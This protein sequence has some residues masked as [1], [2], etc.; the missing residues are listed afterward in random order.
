MSNNKQKQFR[1]KL[2][3]LSLCVALASAACI[4][5]PAFAQSVS[6]IKTQGDMSVLLQQE[7][8]LNFSAGS[9]NFGQK[10][11]IDEQQRYQTIDGLGYAFTQGSAEEI[12]KLSPSAQD[13]LLNEMFHPT[14][15]RGISAVRISIG[16]SDL[17]TSLYSY[18][19]AASSGENFSPDPNKSYYIDIPAHG[20][21]IGATGSG[22]QPYTGANAPS[23]ADFEWRFVPSGDGHW[24]IDRAS[25]GSLPR[26]RTDDTNMADMDPNTSSGTWEKWALSPGENA[27]T[28]FLSLPLKGFGNHDRLQVDDNAL[29]RMADNDQSAGTWESFSFTEVGATTNFSL[30]GPDMQDLIPLLQKI[31]AINP[32]VKILA[33]PWS[34]PRRMKTNNA[35]V[36]GKLRPASYSEYAQYFVQYIDAMAMNGI[37]I[38]AITPQNEP[39][40]NHNSPSMEMTAQEQFD[41]IDNHLG[42]ALQS[43]NKGNVKIIG[44][45]HNCDNTA[46][47]ITVAQSQFVDGSAF[48]LYAGD[49]SAMTTVKEATGKNVYFT[50]QW[51]QIPEDNTNELFEI[52]FGWHMENVV[53][54]SIRN[55]SKAVFEWNFATSGHTDGGCLACLGAVDIQAGDGVKRNVSY[56]ILS[57][58]GEYL[59]AGATRID[60]GQLS[61]TIHHVAF[62]NP[63]GSQ[64]LL[65]YNDDLIS[66]QGISVDWDGKFLD[67]TIPPNSAVTLHW[68]DVPPTPTPTP[69][70]VPSGKVEAEDFSAMSGVLLEDTTDAGGGQNVGWIDTG[71]WMRYDLILDAAGS[72]DL[73]LRVAS[74]LS[75]GAFDVALNGVLVAQVTVPNTNGWQQWQ[76]LTR[77]I[78]VATAGAQTLT[79]NATGSGWNVNW[80]ELNRVG[81]P[82]PTPTPTPTATPTPTPTATPTPTP[83]P[84]ATPTPTPTATPTPTPTATPT[85]TPTATPTP[86][87]TPT[88]TPDP[89]NGV[90]CS[91]VNIYPN[92]T[93]KDWDGGPTTHNEPGDPIVLAG[94]LYR[95][96]W[97][98]NSLPG[99]DASWTEEGAC[100]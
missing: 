92:W 8:N 2:S 83:T 31:L 97:Y 86:T 91:G 18:S 11:S 85:P 90:D 28:Y 20:L 65:A 63:D 100:L 95:A 99:S 6:L 79:I 59:D 93:T 75:G 38:W 67:Y 34:A 4:Q 35:W 81:E 43:A 10:I 41:F 52:D 77:T 58:L 42:P 13:A 73:D 70:P 19:E 29:V 82:T 76:T 64:V 49:I 14:T 54:G 96:N 36:G 56:Y 15:G 9:S 3:A 33:T 80:F 23:G 22:E 24:F 5:S 37:P 44:F 39:E 12:N 51:T 25:G 74:D 68:D 87:V 84:T 21:R 69:T 50:E 89:G 71:D 26:L 72:Y 45:D 32:D 66:S 60:S 48:H 78:N 27:G 57:Q 30:D 94:V 7:N 62:E 46:Y 1:P 61:G 55:W 16:A 53:I 88:P 40:N 98:T 17:S 47:P